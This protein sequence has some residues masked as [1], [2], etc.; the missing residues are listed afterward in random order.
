MKQKSS[1]GLFEKAENAS[2]R[3][4]PAQKENTLSPKAPSENGSKEKKERLMGGSH[5]SG[6][7]P[8]RARRRPKAAVVAGVDPRRGRVIAGYLWIH[9]VLPRRWVVDLAVGEHHVDG[10]TISGGQWFGRG[11]NS[12]VGAA[13]SKLVRG[14]ERWMH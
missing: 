13:N 11:W 4:T 7:N 10:D 1:R 3:N 6:S 8:N 5:P 12:P 2:V 14:L 9:G